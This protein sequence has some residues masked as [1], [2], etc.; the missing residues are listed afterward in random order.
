[1]EGLAHTAKGEGCTHDKINEVKKNCQF[2]QKEVERTYDVER[3]TCEDCKEIQKQ[4]YHKRTKKKY[5]RLPHIE[6]VEE[7][8]KKSRAHLNAKQDV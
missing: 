8:S 4:S 3:A 2:C 7:W 5:K 1:M 6:S